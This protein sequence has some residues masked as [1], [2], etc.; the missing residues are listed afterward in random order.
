MRLLARHGEGLFWLARYLERAA[1]LARIIEMQSSFGTAQD[2][3]AGWAS[4]LALYND[5]ARFKATHVVAA[6]DIIATNIARL[7]PEP[8][9]SAHD[10]YLQRYRDT[11]QARVIGREV[12]VRGL[13]K[14]GTSFPLEL[15]I[16]EIRLPDGRFFSGFVRD[17]TARKKSE[18][19][20]R[21]AA[22]NLETQN[23]E[24]ERARDQALAA[25]QAKSAFL[26]TMSHEIR[27]PMNAIIGMAELLMDTPLNEEQK[28][29]VTR[30]T[31]AANALLGLINDILDLSKIESG[32][33][34]LE[35]I[36]FDPG[37]LVESV[38]DLMAGRA[39]AQ[40]LDLITYVAPDV[41][42]QVIGDPTRFRQIL[43]NL[44]GN[45]VKFTD[46]GTVVIRLQSPTPPL[47]DHLHLSVADTGIGIPSDKLDTIFDNFTQ[48]DSSTTRK[49]GGTGL[50][51]SICRRLT[52]MMNGRLWAESSE[53]FGST[54]HAVLRL[55]A[56]ETGRA[57]APDRCLADRH[58]LVV[59]DHELNRQIVRDLVTQAG[60]RLSEA[61]DTA[62]AAAFLADRAGNQDPIDLLVVDGDDCVRSLR[63]AAKGPYCPAIVLSIDPRKQK[64]ALDADG[65]VRIGKPLRRKPLL[66]LIRQVLAQRTQTAGLVT[67]SGPPESASLERQPPPVRTVRILLVE[68]LEDNRDVVM[69]FLKHQAVAMTVAENGLEA[70]NAFKAGEFDLVLMDMQMPVMDGYAATGAIR[71]WE[72]ERHR[73][74]T[75]IVALTAN[76]FPE[77]I[78]K[79]L[80]AGCTAHLTKPIKKKTLLEAVR[81]YAH[82]PHHQEA[83]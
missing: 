80:H 34:T 28:I 42:T 55:P 14:D 58:I 82:H 7:M 36:P 35:Q 8:Y 44:V 70:V 45:A 72:R 78:E 39:H 71:Q 48:V 54:F 24:L 46:R 31:R 33:M 69:L 73:P 32:R 52:G 63:A 30:F 20:L 64:D 16:S 79:S 56:V 81:T 5:E 77:E 1:S 41:P 68:D 12:E 76:A 19:A 50:G 27:T 9:Q 13:K 47:P 61:T 21:V 2:H 22:E 3:D 40:H 26:A 11:G 65:C 29:Y 43:I 49:Y 51:L 37:E 10:G 18:E 75:P 25:T 38:G 60:G 83:A 62:T 67:A 15:A 57:Q 23:R 74:P 66:D 6:A 59:A 53:G 17:I 4:I